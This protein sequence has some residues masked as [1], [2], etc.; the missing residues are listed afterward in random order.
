MRLYSFPRLVSRLYKT[1]KGNHRLM[2][3]LPHFPAAVASVGGQ[4]TVTDR[5]VYCSFNLVGLA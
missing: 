5:L 2:I 1:R 4:A 3:S